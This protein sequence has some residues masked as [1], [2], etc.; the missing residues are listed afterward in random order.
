MSVVIQNGPAFLDLT[1][2]A[3][4]RN[5]GMFFIL[6]IGYQK[7][8]P[9]VFSVVFHLNN[10]IEKKVVNRSSLDLC[11]RKGKRVTGHLNAPFGR[12]MEECG[13]AGLGDPCGNPE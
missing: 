1:F 8:G 6:R 12:K 11:W 2:W 5:L 7:L 13:V 10:V 9:Y 3:I 4:S